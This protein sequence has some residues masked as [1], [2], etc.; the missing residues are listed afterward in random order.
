[1]SFFEF[2]SK[3]LL[4]NWKLNRE[5]HWYVIYCPRNYLLETSLAYAFAENFL[6]Y[7]KGITKKFWAQ[8]LKFS[9]T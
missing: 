3:K 7:I 4:E 2:F 6:V 5:A 9:R 8:G 1:M